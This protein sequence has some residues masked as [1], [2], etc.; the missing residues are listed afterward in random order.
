MNGLLLIFFSKIYL[1]FFFFLNVFI[2]VEIYFVE[3]RCFI[4]YCCLYRKFFFFVYFSDCGNDIYDFVCKIRKY[5]R[6][7]VF[8]IL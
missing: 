1:V 8:C 3:M 2:F 4:L 6:I 7:E 5:N